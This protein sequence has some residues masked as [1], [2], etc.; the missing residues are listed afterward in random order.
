M[1]ASESKIVFV[2]KFPAARPEAMLER[3]EE[4]SRTVSDD[5]KNPS[6]SFEDFL[7]KISEIYTYELRPDAEKKA[8]RFISL[9]IAV[10]RDFE[11][12]TEITRREHE[13]DVT[14]DL[15][16]GW[17]GRDI[18][19]AFAAVL[20]LADDFTLTC[21]P[22]EPNCVRISMAYHTHDL[23]SHGKKVEWW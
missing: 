23:Y 2:H 12:D 14:M 6:A 16:Y 5:G 21:D 18:K 7:R 15:Y 11:I 8:E 3:A 22:S 9:A 10:C 4:L 1:E 17:H 13:I 20:R 19:N